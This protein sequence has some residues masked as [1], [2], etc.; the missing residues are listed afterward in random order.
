MNTG[1]P[2]Y[3]PDGRRLYDEASDEEADADSARLR[4]MPEHAGNRGSA[5]A[6]ESGRHDGE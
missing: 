1:D 6:V 4:S 3:T 2:D 5:G